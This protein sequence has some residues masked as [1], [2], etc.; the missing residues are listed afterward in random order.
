MSPDLS[1]NFDGGPP[2]GYVTKDSGAREVFDSGMR[3]DTQDG[4]VLWHLTASGPMLARWAGL[5]TRGAVKYTA[6]NWM[7]AVGLLEHARFKASAFRHFMLWFYGHT[8]EDHAA[9]VF[10][11]INGA[12][13]VKARSP[14]V[15]AAERRL[16][17]EYPQ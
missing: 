9:G 1:V 10:F 7:K 13:Y 8:D 5:L 12:E 15:V 2:D 17:L 14:E 3:R 11:N 4:K 16:V 6:D